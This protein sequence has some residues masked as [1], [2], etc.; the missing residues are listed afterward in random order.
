M[1]GRGKRRK[2]KDLDPTGVYAATAEVDEGQA[3]AS[4]SIATSNQQTTGNV[5]IHSRSQPPL[6]V[7]DMIFE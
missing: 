7:S 4:D 3:H 2:K 5:P 1:T 6:S